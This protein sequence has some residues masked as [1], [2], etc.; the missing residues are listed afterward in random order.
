M[1]EGRVQ[2]FAG[3]KVP[4]ISRAVSAPDD[5]TFAIR[6]ELPTPGH[7]VH[8]ERWINALQTPRVAHLHLRLIPVQKKAVA[9][10]GAETE[11]IDEVGFAHGVAHAASARNLPELN[12]AYFA[13]L[14]GCGGGQQALT[15]VTQ[16]DPPHRL[17]MDQR[18]SH[19]FARG[20]SPQASRLVLTR[21]SQQAAI[22]AER[23]HGD[24]V[25]VPFE[26]NHR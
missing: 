21:G 7:A 16:N 9:R 18:D 11:A 17:G 1:P 23:Q 24:G 4:D 10:P 8:F 14:G 19:G 5:A 26:I 22:G 25:G 2:K 12:E 20:Q 13:G 6:A 3:F 15:V